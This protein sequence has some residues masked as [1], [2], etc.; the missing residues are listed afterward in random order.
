MQDFDIPAQEKFSKALEIL[1]TAVR[2]RA[3]PGAVLAVGHEGKLAVLPAGRLDYLED[4]PPATAETI[5]DLASLTKPVATTT[6]AMIL[7][8]RGML[9]LDRLV[10]DYLPDF[11]QPFVTSVDPLYDARNE[12]TVRHL[13]A[14]TSGLP[15]Y[16]QFFLRAREKSHVL[17]E[18]LALPLE[19]AP[20]R[21]TLYSDPGFILLGEI[22]ERVSEKKLDEWCQK[23][24]FEPLR[25]QDTCFNPAQDRWQRIA[26]TELEESFRNRLIRGEVQDENA[27]VM[28]GVAGHAGL[29]GTVGDMASFCRMMLQE[30]KT[31]GSQLVQAATIR[32]FTQAVHVAEGAMQEASGRG[33]GWDKPS[34][35]SSSGRYFSRRSYGH[36]GFTG[37]SLWID[38]QKALFVI[39]LTNRVHPSRSNE[40]IRQV[41]PAV[42]DAVVEALGFD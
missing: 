42:H 5:Y 4:S 11:L 1:N 10:A 13:L 17:E 31:N 26:P 29:F 35:P 24:I 41:R 15:A 7:A 16:E 3:F 20:G 6:A 32:E 2:Q 28:G 12:V 34:E 14:H 27:W 22:V 38:P 18:A 40:A 30:G 36:L 25:M 23:E 19:D 33:L 8:D 21:K 9:R 37:T 39:L